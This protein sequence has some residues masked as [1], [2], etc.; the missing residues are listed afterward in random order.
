MSF[1]C[2]TAIALSGV[3]A[4]AALTGA[5]FLGTGAA[6]SAASAAQASTTPAVKNGNGQ[7]LVVSKRRGLDP[8]GQLLTVKGSGFNPAVGIYVALCVTPARGEKPSPCGGGIDMD[9]SSKASAWISSN[10]PPYARNL[11][12]PY[13]KN[14]SFTT[15]IKVS[16]MIGDVDCRAVACSIV[17]RADHLRAADR[18][19][20]IAIPVT[21]R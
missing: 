8:N 10:P 4:A 21:F 6:A 20:D 3:I 11:T 15:R 2:S 7:T 16:P 9:G 12:T 5:G 14:G 17:A 19:F 13:R 18:R 1:R